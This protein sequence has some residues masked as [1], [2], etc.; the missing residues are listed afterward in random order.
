MGLDQAF[1][2]HNAPTG[3]ITGLGVPT[4]D[5]YTFTHGLFGGY[6]GGLRKT[7]RI[8]KSNIKDLLSSG[9]I[10]SALEEIE[11]EKEFI[12]VTVGTY[13]LT[14]DEVIQYTVGGG[15]GYGDPLDR[16]PALV[17]RDIR[18][19]ALS[20]ETAERIYGVVISQ[21]QAKVELEATERNRRAMIEDRLRR[22]KPSK[23][24][25]SLRKWDM[26]GLSSE[27]T[28]AVQ[29]TEYLW[30]AEKGGKEYSLW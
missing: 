29:I 13:E 11:G 21:N 4:A 12:Q 25:D 30:L 8:R 5:T 20:V 18:K 16:D 26:E 10:P 1:T 24:R 3:S 22:G 15:G 27:N 23:K 9:K 14:D 6:P 7:Y 2:A 19:G 17:L 28:N